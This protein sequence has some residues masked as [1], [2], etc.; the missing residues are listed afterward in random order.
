MDA[1]RVDLDV[2]NGVDYW[3]D[4]VTVASGNGLEEE[5][6]GVTYRTFGT[7]LHIWV[8][9]GDI[10]TDKEILD[11]FSNLGAVKLYTS[12]KKD[13]NIYSSYKQESGTLEKVIIRHL[14][15]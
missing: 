1:C 15:P 7:S 10:F 2:I 12:R 3:E 11:D 8:K 4:P 9:S 14:E 5:E 6:M 13:W